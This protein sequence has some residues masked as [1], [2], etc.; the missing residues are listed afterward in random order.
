MDRKADILIGGGLLLLAAALCLTAHH[1]WEEH[2]AAVSAER[3]VR[4]IEE[5]L[6]P[7]EPSVT[8]R[9]GPEAGTAVPDD[10]PEAEPPAMEIDGERYIG[11]LELP[12]L[13]LTLPVMGEWSYPKLKLAPCRF[14]GSVYLDDMI[15]AAH[16]YPKH[17][18]GLKD[19][20]IGDEIV[21]TDI[22]RRIFRY[23]VSETGQL[24]SSELEALSAGDWDLT[25]FT[26]TIGSGERV[27]VRCERTEG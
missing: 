24:G 18:G 5:R 21:F 26:C 19:L 16:N 22:D 9:P 23:R 10:P 14:S 3:L 7:P 8:A 11:T 2:R 20:G 15:V 27:V 17:F 6:P 12:S 13:G 4:E 25:L 1:L